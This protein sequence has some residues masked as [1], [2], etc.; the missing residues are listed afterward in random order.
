MNR[1]LIQILEQVAREKGLP[2]KVIV[3][4]VVTAIELAAKKRDKSRFDVEYEETT[5]TLHLYAIKE[6][7]ETVTNPKL[8]IDLE[9][10]QKLKPGAVVGDEVFIERDISDLGRISAQKAKQIISQK[11]K[12][13][14]KRKVYE[15]YQD[16]IGDVV[17]GNVQRVDNGV[18]VDLGDAEAIL[19]RREQI[20][21]EFYKRG[22]TIR[23][24]I[25][26]VRMSSSGKWPQIILSRTCD[27]FL[28]RLFEIEVPE[29]AEG[30]VE[31]MGVA[32]D[33]GGR[34]KIGVS[35]VDRNVDP[36]GACVGLR[37]ARI[38]SIV[39]E[40]RGEKIDIIEW[41]DE[42]EVLVARAMTPA[43][44]QSASVD[45]A[46]Q[47][48]D[49][50]V[51]DDELAL[52]IGK[53]G[54]NAKLAVRLTKWKINI[55]SE[56][57][58]RAAV[59]E[60]FEKALSQTEF[61]DAE[62]TN[63]QTEAALPEPADETPQEEVGEFESEENL[64]DSP[65]DDDDRDDDDDQNEN[66]EGD[67]DDLDDDD[68][69]NENEEDDDDDLDDD[70]DRNEDEEDDDDDLDDDEDRDEEDDDR[71]DDDLDDDDLEESDLFS[72]PGMEGDMVE[73]LIEAGFPFIEDIM[74]STVEDMISAGIDEHLARKLLDMA[75]NLGGGN[76]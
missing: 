54:Q 60:S 49:I 27:E 10:A 66:E 39:R 51:P 55:I 35:S 53:R 68:D 30:I 20:P 57:E 61:E 28:I 75:Q 7:V 46:D 43:K 45:Y 74:M 12:E 40:L 72:L 37:G 52:A 24:L 15:L 36:V 9:A 41:S 16:R 25:T 62:E 65:L 22:D 26:D 33:S 47:I 17:I 58:R 19:P 32:R 34:S 6:V 50:V 4:A 59:Q 1:E 69:R 56:S 2:V 31:L 29:I 64:N 5:G 8:E 71:D 23:A 70:D 21:G 11:V 48:V 67:D 13:A 73:Q 76:R 18:T 44:V 38:Q 63:S 14:E 3:E 42:P